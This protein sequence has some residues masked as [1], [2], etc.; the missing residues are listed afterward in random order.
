MTTARPS[1]PATRQVLGSPRAALGPRE[2]S[3]CPHRP[4][5]TQG[6]LEP[7]PS[8]T[9]CHTPRRHPVPCRRRARTPRDPT[10]SSP[11]GRDPRTTSRSHEPPNRQQLPTTRSSSPL[12]PCHWQRS[13]PQVENRSYSPQYS[14]AYSFVIHYLTALCTVCTHYSTAVSTH[15]CHTGGVPSRCTGC[16]PAR[17]GPSHD[18]R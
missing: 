5:S 9:A 7:T 17:K 2:D 14:T 15:G 16:P 13:A 18:H 10:P 1:T 12:R 4:A 11:V 3:P 6:S 8:A